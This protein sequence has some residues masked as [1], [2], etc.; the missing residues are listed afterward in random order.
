M[1]CLDSVQSR[2][3]NFK[4]GEVTVFSIQNVRSYSEFLGQEC[5]RAVAA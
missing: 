5:R 4:T 3:F 2:E 1:F